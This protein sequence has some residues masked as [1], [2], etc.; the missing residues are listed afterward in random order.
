MQWR[1]FCS[2]C[3]RKFRRL[4]HKFAH[5]KAVHDIKPREKENEPDVLLGLR[6]GS[7][8]DGDS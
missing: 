7:F 3:G 8:Q 1:F 6:D 2:L 4:W 5:L